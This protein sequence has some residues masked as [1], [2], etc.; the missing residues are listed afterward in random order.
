ML[1]VL[2]LFVINIKLGAIDDWRQITYNL[3][4]QRY[5]PLIIYRH[6]L[7]VKSYIIVIEG[8]YKLVISPEISTV[9]LKFAEMFKKAC[10]CGVFGGKIGLSITSKTFNF[11]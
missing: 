9:T 1:Y 11:N 10:I 8:K 3:T 6:A 4:A 7:S 5:G 2:P